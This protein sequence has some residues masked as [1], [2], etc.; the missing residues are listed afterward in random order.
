MSWCGFCLSR[1]AFQM[2]WCVFVSVILDRSG[3]CI[4]RPGYQKN[5]KFREKLSEM[6]KIYPELGKFMENMQNL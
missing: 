6:C 3:W 1:S 5:V 2:L 4:G